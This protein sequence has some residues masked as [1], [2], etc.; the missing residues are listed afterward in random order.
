MLFKEPFACW[1][2]FVKFNSG[3]FFSSWNL[4]IGFLLV[5]LILF[6][7]T[8]AYWIL[9]VEVNAYWFFSS[10][11]FYINLLLLKLILFIELTACYFC[12]YG[13]YCNL[14]I[15]Y[16]NCCMFIFL[17]VTP[18]LWFFS[19]WN[20]FC[21][22]NSLDADFFRLWNFCVLVFVH[23]TCCTLAFSLRL[24]LTAIFLLVKLWL[25]SSFMEL[26]CPDFCS[27]N[28]LQ[29]GFFSSFRL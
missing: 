13:T 23:E 24:G 7:E 8:F 9:F 11:N 4:Y 18:V 1:S 10:W 21:S 14:I 28:L 20:R 19:L 25:F 12:V 3:W 22:W 17:F 15:V 16:E 29:V 26:L 6:M 27:L 2:F 5:K